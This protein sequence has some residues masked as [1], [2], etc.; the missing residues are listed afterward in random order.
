MKGQIREICEREERN[1]RDGKND[2]SDRREYD[3]GTQTD[4]DPDVARRPAKEKPPVK[5]RWWGA[6]R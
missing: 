3:R 1:R 5:K 6:T 2:R 4:W